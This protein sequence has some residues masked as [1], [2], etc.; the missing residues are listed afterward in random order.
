MKYGRSV[1]ET[2]NGYSK[3]TTSRLKNATPVQ[4]SKKGGGGP[5]SKFKKPYG[6]LPELTHS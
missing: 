3:I 1:I 4:N 6:R 2:P 5:S